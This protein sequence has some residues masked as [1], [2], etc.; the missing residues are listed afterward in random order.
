MLIRQQLY[1]RMQ[2]LRAEGDRLNEENRLLKK[3]FA[4]LKRQQQEQFVASSQAI[5]QA[6]ERNRQL[7]QT[8]AHAGQR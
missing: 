1:H 6:E 2:W 7:V 4:E 8:E 3:R 5:E